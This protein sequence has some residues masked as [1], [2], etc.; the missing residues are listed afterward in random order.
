M[1]TEVTARVE[2]PWVVTVSVGLDGRQTGRCA[3]CTNIVFTN[4]PQSAV[5]RET[6]AHFA[7]AHRQRAAVRRC[8]MCGAVGCNAVS[9]RGLWG[10]ANCGQGM[11]A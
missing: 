7:R 10:C 9:V 6:A 3:R 11:F 2:R 5:V 1:A 4:R 8:E